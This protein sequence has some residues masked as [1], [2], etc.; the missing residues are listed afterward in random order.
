[1]KKLTTLSNMAWC[2]KVRMLSFKLHDCQLLK[3]R[4]PSNVQLL[5]S[6]KSIIILWDIFDKRHIRL[7]KSTSVKVVC[8]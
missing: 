7:K 1:M 8:K 6:D 4:Q 3:H 5:T 2:T